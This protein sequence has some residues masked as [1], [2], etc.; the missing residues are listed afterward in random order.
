M[1]DKQLE[2]GEKVFLAFLLEENS[3]KRNKFLINKRKYLLE[4]IWQKFIVYG[5]ETGMIHFC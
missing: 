2:N 5:I 1:E 4:C 3:I